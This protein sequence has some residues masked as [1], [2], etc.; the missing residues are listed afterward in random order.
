MRDVDMTIDELRDDTDRFDKA[1]EIAEEIDYDDLYD[2]VDELCPTCGGDGWD[3][4]GVDWDSDDYINGPYDGQ[5]TRCPNCK[6]S[7]LAKDCWYW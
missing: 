5:I 6:G 2:P 3:I 1:A 4:V 7:G